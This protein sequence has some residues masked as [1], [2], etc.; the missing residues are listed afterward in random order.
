MSSTALL[1]SGPNSRDPNALGTA[2]DKLPLQSTIEFHGQG[3]APGFSLSKQSSQYPVNAPKFRSSRLSWASVAL[4]ICE[5][6]RVLKR[7][8]VGIASSFGK[9]RFINGS[10]MRFAERYV[11]GPSPAHSSQEVLPDLWRTCEGLPLFLS[12]LRLLCCKKRHMHV[13]E[14][15]AI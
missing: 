15:F 6:A 9:R 13:I 7:S 12:V 3:S 11:T 14:R 4:N 2:I 10:V 5:V 1:P 8:A